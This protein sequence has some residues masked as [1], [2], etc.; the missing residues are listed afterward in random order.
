MSINWHRG[1]RAAARR[2][3]IAAGTV[4]LMAAVFFVIFWMLS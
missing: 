1:L 4:I 2:V 3:G